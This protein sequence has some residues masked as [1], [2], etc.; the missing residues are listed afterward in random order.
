MGDKMRQG[1]FQEDKIA[2]LPNFINTEKCNED[3]VPSRNDYFCYLGRLSHEKG[4]ATLI[5]AVKNI[6]QKLIVIGDG[7]LLA[8]LESRASSNVN[9]A[10]KKDW[11]EIKAIVGN[12]KFSVIPSEW[13]E[14]NPLSVIEALCLGT[15]VLGANIGGIPELI[16][17]SS[18]GDVFES[19]NVTDLSAKIS[20]MLERDFDYQA[21]ADDGRKKY[22]E[23]SYY[24]Q[25]MNIYRV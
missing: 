2:V 15:P 9:F 23:N 16:D 12:A 10:G 6:P 25:L 8:E 4:I 7:P 14:N 20:R 19:G 5:D 18:N 13:Y 17:L 21:I 1:G 11:D 3:V 22:N 24:D